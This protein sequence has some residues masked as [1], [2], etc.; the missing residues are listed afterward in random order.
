MKR[1]LGAV[2]LDLMSVKNSLKLGVIFLG[3]PTIIGF[4]QKQP[5]LTLGIALLLTSIMCGIVF[6][7][8]EKNHLAKL[9]AVLPLRKSEMIA[10]RYL[11]ALLLMCVNLG[12]GTL[13]SLIVSR[14]TGTEIEWLGFCLVLA[15]G[16]AY[17]C[18]MVSVGFPVYL[19]LEYQKA[20]AIANIPMFGVAIAAM[21]LGRRTGLPTNFADAIKFFNDHMALLPLLGAALGLALLC[22][23]MAISNGVYKYK[24]L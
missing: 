3:I 5:L 10:G 21:V 7:V 4:F 19:H 20:Y 13:L 17:C 22:V 23:S 9:Y 6:Q 11:Y 8:H 14:I 16:F 2:K 1:I 15:V 24:E 18:L 12:L